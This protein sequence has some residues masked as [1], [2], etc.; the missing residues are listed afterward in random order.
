M[1]GWGPEGHR[2]VARI[3][4]SQL[5]PAA[6][7]HVAAILAPGET[8]ASLA[9][10]ADEI[11]RT[12]RDTGPWHYIDIPIEQNHVDM[13]RD[14]AKSDCVIA[15]IEDLRKVLEDP[16]TQP[17]PRREALL[18]LVH[19]I[20]DM[21]QP[22]HSSDHHDQGGNEVHVVFHDRQ[23]NLHSVWDSGLLG[24]MGAEDVLFQDLARDAQHHA[25][26]WDKGTV[27]Q[28]AEQSHKAAQKVAYGKLP[29]VASGTPL[30]LDAGYE[31]LA[32]AVIRVQ[33][34]KAGDRLA[35]LLNAALK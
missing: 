8:L 31:K 30:P 24:R 7:D 25:K 32:D 23:T 17:V 2:L 27:V 5:T 1:L 12:R 20:G 15:K 13:T 16:A 19:F 33:I 9:S 34:E 29:K 10:W 4:D 35:A 14:C 21:H 28:W 3:A 26:K 18:F 6:R 22:L 11:R